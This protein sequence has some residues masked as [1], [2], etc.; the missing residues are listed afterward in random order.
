MRSTLPFTQT[1][2]TKWL[3]Y[4]RSPIIRLTSS[5]IPPALVHP[6]TTSIHLFCVYLSSLYILLYYYISSSAA[7]HLPYVLHP[8]TLS[9]KRLSND[10]F[11]S[12]NLTYP[13]FNL[14]IL[15]VPTIAYH[16]RYPSLLL[17]FLIPPDVYT[18]GCHIYTSVLRLSIP[19]CKHLAYS[20]LKNYPI[21]KASN[22][23][24]FF[25]PCLTV[26]TTSTFPLPSLIHFTPKYLNSST[27]FKYL[28]CKLI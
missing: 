4:I 28:P 12:Y 17:L 20:T 9:S 16:A 10:F 14:S 22:A 6:L 23:S 27:S 13:I 15:L 25:P 1:T 11:T 18:L 2:Y 24:L 26:F 21:I 3:H 5:E 8:K 7:Y 19:S